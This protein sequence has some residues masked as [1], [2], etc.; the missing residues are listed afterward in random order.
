MPSQARSWRSHRRVL[1]NILWAASHFLYL[2]TNCPRNPFDTAVHSGALATSLTKSARRLLLLAPA[3]L[4]LSACDSSSPTATAVYA[5]AGQ[6][7][8]AYSTLR[9]Q[10][11]NPASFTFPND[12]SGAHYLIEG[13]TGP[14][15]SGQTITAVFTLDGDGQLLA[16]E[17]TSS[18]RVRLSLQRSGDNLSAIGDMQSYRWWSS[19]Y[20]ELVSPGTYRLSEKTSPERWTDVYARNGSA[21]PYLFNAMLSNL[22][23]IGMTFGGDFAGHGVYCPSGSVKFTLVS[24]TIGADP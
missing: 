15:K 13:A 9:L 16:T 7:E 5:P 8:L 11:D 14:L 2:Y 1:P 17:G 21:V 20:V 3:L 22:G 12:T 4:V 10:S 18:A 6:W 23:N 24:F 19:N